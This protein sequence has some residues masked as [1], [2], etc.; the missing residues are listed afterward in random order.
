MKVAAAKAIA[1]CVPRAEREAGRIVPP[2]FHPGVGPSVGAAV[3]AAA[4]EDGVTR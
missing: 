4:R 3:A 1:S 2:V